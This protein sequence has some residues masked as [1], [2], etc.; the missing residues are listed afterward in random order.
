MTQNERDLLEMLKFEL[1]FLECGGYEHSARTPWRATSTFHDSPICLNFNDPTRPHSCSKCLL[2][3]FVPQ[4][5]RNE[6]SPCWFIPLT[7][8][9]ETVNYYVHCGTKLELEEALATWLRRTIKS[10]EDKHAG[11]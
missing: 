9:G 6:D 2:L 11:K 5:R 7:A 3:Q 8:L 4:E 1:Q 10:I